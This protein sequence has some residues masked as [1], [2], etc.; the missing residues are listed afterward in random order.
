MNSLSAMGSSTAPKGEL[1][2][3]RA[4]GPSSRSVTA[5]APTMASRQPLCETSRKAAASGI[6]S[7]LSTSAADHQARPCS[8]LSAGLASDTLL[9]SPHVSVQDTLV[10]S[11]GSPS[12]DTLSHVMMLDTA[13][14]P[15]GGLGTRLH[16]ITRWLP[17][18]MLPIG[19]KPVLYWTLD[20]AADPGV[21]RALI[22]TNPHKPMLE[23]VARNYPGPLELEFVPQ[24]HPRGLGDALL[25]ARDHLA[26]SPFLAVLPDNLFHG[27]NPTADV[28]SV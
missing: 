16:P 15:C 11:G 20:E 14:I 27:S 17:K 2:R 7:R 6:R 8:P 21:L 24:D 10:R 28:L 26:G 1:P 5:T 18:E 13:V 3:R 19:L 22:I 12:L 23:A 9:P 25:R 4:T